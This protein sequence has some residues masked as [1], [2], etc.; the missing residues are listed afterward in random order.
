MNDYLEVPDRNRLQAMRLPGSFVD[1]VLRQCSRIVGSR[2]FV[3]MH[4]QSRDF[5]GYV[6][7]KKL[8]DQEEEI[9]ETTIAVNVFGEPPDYD[10]AETGRIRGTAGNLREKLSQYYASEGKEDPIVIHIP[11][12]TFV[13]EF[14]DCRAWVG[15]RSFDNW[16]PNED[17][18]HLCQA[19]AD[20][21]A[22]RIHR[23]GLLEA[24]R[25]TDPA[26]LPVGNPRAFGVRGS[27]ECRGQEVRLNVSLS[28][29]GAGR[30]L[31]GASFE[32]PRDEILRTCG[33]AAQSLLSIIHARSREGSRVDMRPAAA[34]AGPLRPTP[35]SLHASS[36]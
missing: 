10:S 9:K 8:L 28:D 6:V 15:I 2:S 22:Y 26:Q 18:S 20:E 35:P 1:D 7:A 23:P 14:Q 27:V 36:I 13:P 34:T 30:V 19:V 16:N 21:V 29:L 24:V 33:A 3:R 5:L 4:Q 12:G 17:Q 11:V 25:L 32:G 31:F